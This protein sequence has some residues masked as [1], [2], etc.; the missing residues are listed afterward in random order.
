[1]TGQD[2][3]RYRD[4]H[5]IVDQ[6][7]IFAVDGRLDRRVTRGET[8]STDSP[9]KRFPDPSTVRRFSTHVPSDNDVE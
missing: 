9:G 2:E 3:R 6:L 1:V 8:F 4:H 7:A 5:G